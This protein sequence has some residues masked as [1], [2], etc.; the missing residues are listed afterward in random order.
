MR[1]K[2]SFHTLLW[3]SIL[4]VSFFASIALLSSPTLFAQSTGGRIRGTVTDQS[5]ATVTA[6]KVVITK[7]KDTPKL[8][9]RERAY[10]NAVKILYGEGE[11]HARDVAYSAAMEKNWSVQAMTRPLNSGILI[12]GI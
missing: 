11:K 6:A 10:L 7:I 3:N 4:H 9:A 2:R 5:G 12:P 1:S 8:T